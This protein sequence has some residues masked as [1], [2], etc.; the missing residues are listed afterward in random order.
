VKASIG[1]WVGV[2]AW[3]I[4]TGDPIVPRPEKVRLPRVLGG[5]IEIL[6]YRPE[7]TIAEKGVTI[8]ERGISSTRWRDYIDIVQLFTHYDIDREQLLESARA[9]ARY[10]GVE[11]GP[12]AQ[13]VAGYGAI[14]QQ[15]WAAWRRKE[16][17]EGISE[18]SLDK[19]I[20]QVSAYLDPVFVERE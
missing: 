15:R 10:R 1:C 18:E 6:G 20:A 5:E 19:Q 2:A 9:V 17:V 14:A 8:P 13:H 4:S 3:D 11:L 7:T 12:T 16:G